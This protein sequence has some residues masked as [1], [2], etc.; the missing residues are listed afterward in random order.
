[1]NKISLERY[2]KMISLIISRENWGCEVGMGLFTIYLLVLLN[3]ELCDYFTYS[4]NK[5]IKQI[6]YSYILNHRTFICINR[7][8]TISK[9]GHDQNIFVCM[10]MQFPSYQAM[11]NLLTCLS[12]DKIKEDVKSQCN[13]EKKKEFSNKCGGYIFRHLWDLSENI[14]F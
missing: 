2:H 7:I 11:S 14:Y 12:F 6:K 5:I 13:P 4:K 3:F 1:M 8:Y 9:Y 10:Y